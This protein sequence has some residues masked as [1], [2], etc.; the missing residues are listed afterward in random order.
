MAITLISLPVD[1]ITSQD[2]D[3]FAVER[4]DYLR[5]VRAE[6]RPATAEEETLAAAAGYTIS[7][8]Y[9]TAAVNYSGQPYLVDRSDDQYYDIRQVSENGRFVYL[10]TERRKNGKVYDAARDR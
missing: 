3:G 7:R 1:A 6:P 10:Y 8:I 9:K 4:M 5:N 2:G